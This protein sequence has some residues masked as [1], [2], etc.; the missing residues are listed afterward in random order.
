[1]KFNFFKSK[2]K[3]E[4]QPV[5]PLV[6]TLKSI[7]YPAKI[8]MAWAK[9]IEGDLTFLNWLGENGYP[10]LVAASGAI[11]LNGNAR[12]WLMD[13]GYPHLLA[14]VQAAESNRYAIA[15]LERNNL[16]LLSMM[17]KAIDGDKESLI[18][19]QVNQPLDIFVLTVSIKKVKDSIEDYNNDVH[20]FK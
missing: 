9:G 19:V 17:A 4:I 18:W 3:K 20:I 5:K 2:K 8:M 7:D 11:R 1:M 10:E 15:W 13:N 12:K 6:V 16:N 14:F